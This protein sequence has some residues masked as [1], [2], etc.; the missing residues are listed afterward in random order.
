MQSVR[1][2]MLMEKS[3]VNEP[4]IS[5][6]SLETKWRLRASSHK[7][8]LAGKSQINPVLV[9]KKLNKRHSVLLLCHVF[10]LDNRVFFKKMKTHWFYASRKVSE[11]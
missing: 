11:E 2:I 7:K 3:E 6:D 1:I 4:V 8:S 5:H 9:K 10:L